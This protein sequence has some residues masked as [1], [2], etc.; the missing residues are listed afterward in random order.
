MIGRPLRESTQSEI[1]STRREE[2]TAGT[3]FLIALLVCLMACQSSTEPRLEVDPESVDLLVRGGMVVTMDPQYTVHDPGFI[4]I[5]GGILVDL[6]PLEESRGLAAGRTIDASNTLILPGLINGHGHAAMTLFRGLGN[7]VA[8]MEWL[9]QTIF[10]AEAKNVDPDF[11]Y[12]GTLLAARE[13]LESGTTTFVDMYYFEDQV[14]RA[15]S[16]A[17]MRGILAQTVIG[18]PAP[19]YPTPEETLLATEQF[20]QKWKEHPLVIPALGP[21]AAYTNSDEILRASQALAD[22]YDV[23]LVIHVSETRDELRQ[24]EEAHGTTPIR[25]L[26][27]IGLLSDR[28]IAAHVVW[29]TPE[30]IELLSRR[31]VGVIHNPESNMKLASGTAPVPEMLEAGVDVGLGTDGAA[32]NNDLDLFQEMDSMAKLHKLVRGDPTA[33]TARQALTA[34]TMGSARALNLGEAIGSLEA[35]KKADLVILKLTGASA[36]PFYDPYSMAVYSLDGD[37]VDTVIVDGKVV[38]EGGNL[39]TIDRQ[40]LGAKVKM[41]QQ[42]VMRSLTKSAP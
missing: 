9:T 12:W 23:P 21:H 6:G 4:A 19:D 31:G 42:A 24:I 3:P 11:V 35:G 28:M 17:G 29:P 2:S 18:F 32:S 30:D 34:A 27:D 10:P 1:R 38:V 26:E 41:L 15:T 33:I 14:A 37:D 7:D 39:L 36:I 20:I 8:L 25:H 40:E 22:K 13:M 5:R 16:Q